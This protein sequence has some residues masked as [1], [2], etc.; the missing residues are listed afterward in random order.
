[1][2]IFSPCRQSVADFPAIVHWFPLIEIECRQ[3]RNKSVRLDN[4]FYT[5]SCSPSKLDLLS[6]A[7]HAPGSSNSTLRRRF[8]TISFAHEWSDGLEPRWPK[9][10]WWEWE[11]ELVRPCEDFDFR[12][13]TCCCG[14]EDIVRKSCSVWS[15][16]FLEW[17]ISLRSIVRL[18]NDVGQEFEEQGTESLLLIGNSLRLPACR[19]CFEF[20]WSKFDP[21]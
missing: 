16:R 7:F 19:R 18:P 5:E 9:T 17:R 12:Y 20:V 8:W 11:I 3:R 6:F 13:V 10:V 14:R 1:M 2:K 4:E 21:D 15:N